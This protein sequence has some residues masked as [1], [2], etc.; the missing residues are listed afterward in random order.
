MIG[1]VKKLVGWPG[2]P[3]REETKVFPLRGVLG[4][5]TDLVFL[6]YLQEDVRDLVVHVCGSKPVDIYELPFAPRV[7]AASEFLKTKFPQVVN[8]EIEAESAAL[9]RELYPTKGTAQS[10]GKFEAL[11]REW[12]A[13]YGDS[14]EVPQIPEGNW[15]EWV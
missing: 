4:A 14:F 8:P 5:C 12:V 6:P 2:A 15:R 10:R 7:L 11:M 1:I 3:T 9:C 13:R